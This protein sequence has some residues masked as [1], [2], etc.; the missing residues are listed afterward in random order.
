VTDIVVG[1]SLWPVAKGFLWAWV[2]VNHDAVGSS[3][4]RRASK[5]H[6]EVATSGSVGWIHD[7]RQMRKVMHN[8]H[9]RDVQGAPRSP[10][11]GAD[12]PL[13]QDNI[14]ITAQRDVLRGH[15]PFLDSRI[16]AAL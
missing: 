4:D 6:D 1:K 16:H 10:F 11:E 8:W 2:D 13:T 5:R 3:S 12:A 15:Q 7:N 9:C 14:E